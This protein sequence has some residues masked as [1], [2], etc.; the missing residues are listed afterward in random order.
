[1]RV[2]EGLPPEVWCPACLDLQPLTR[3]QVLL[4]HTHP[5][6]L[7]RGVPLPFSRWEGHQG[8]EI[9]PTT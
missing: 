7:I 2:K 9:A 1:M 6:F 8:G 3:S 5:D 4:H